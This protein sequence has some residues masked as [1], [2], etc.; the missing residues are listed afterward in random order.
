MDQK[1]IGSSGRLSNDEM[2]QRLDGMSL[3]DLLRDA[4]SSED[5]IAAF[6]ISPD[7]KL[8]DSIGLVMA[9]TGKETVKRYLRCMQCCAEHEDG[10]SDDAVR[11]G[12]CC[13]RC[14]DGKGG[15]GGDAGDHGDGR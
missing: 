4:F 7:P 13:R 10:E 5:G 14:I 3:G 8:E 11:R 12:G 15:S 9:I 2:E 1:I 6:A